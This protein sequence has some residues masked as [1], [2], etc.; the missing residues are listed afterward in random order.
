MERK[1]LAV[2]TLRT[3]DVTE[4]DPAVIW[5][6]QLRRRITPAWGRLFTFGKEE[7]ISFAKNLIVYKHVLGNL[8]SKLLSRM[9]FI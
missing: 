9:S 3:S 6:G 5:E 4:A 2:K 8:V 1:D 7:C